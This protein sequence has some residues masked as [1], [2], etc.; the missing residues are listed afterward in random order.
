MGERLMAFDKLFS[1]ITIGS[2]Q[3]PNRVVMSPMTT[4]YGTPEQE[5]SERLM[6]YLEA[7]AQGGVGL[8][9]LEVCSVALDHRYQP[10]SLSLSE[11][12]FIP[13]HQN[14]VAMAHKHGARIQPQ[15]THPGPESL[16]PFY[17]GKPGIGPS[18]NV[19]PA[20]FQSCRPLDIEEIPAV[21]QQYAD[22][23]VRAQK[24]GY[25]GIELHAAHAYM[26]LGS[27]L[28]PLRN[29]RSDEYGG[30][31][32][33]GRARLL[34]ETL[35]AIRA[36][37][38]TEFPITVSLSGYERSPGGSEMNENQRLAQ[39]LV[40][41][42]ASAFRISGGSTDGLVSQM[43]M[44]SDYKDGINVTAAESIKRVV[45]V[46]VMVV[47]R[48]HTP[49]HAEQILE[50]GSADL[51]AM[52][53]PFLADPEWPR[54]ARSGKAAD[55]RR[56]I[57]CENCIDSMIDFQNLNCAVNARTGRE[58]ANV[59]VATEKAKYVLVVGGGPAGMEVARVANLRGH[60]VTL[61]ERQKRLGGAML[62][63]STVH[64]DN[65]PFYQ[66]LTRQVENSTID[67]R[68]GQEA[69]TETIASENPDVVIVATGATVETPVIPGAGQKHVYSGAQ[70][71]RMVEALADEADFT[72]LPTLLRGP[73]SWLMRYISPYLTPQLIRQLTRIW[74]PLGNRVVI[75]GAD[76]AA[77]ELA[78]FLVCR[79]RKVSMLES[80][81]RFAQ[82]IGPKRRAEHMDRLDRLGVTINTEADC[83]TILADAVRYKTAV[84]VR[85][86]IPADSV[87]LAG[88]PVASTQ[89]Y[90]ALQGAAFEVHA[91][92]DCTGLGLIRKAT[93]DAMRLACSI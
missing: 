24:A 37:V 74:L 2:M 28:S 9:T 51:I 87:I 23:A 56:C 71:R 50:D 81:K 6:A 90:E 25:D 22:G 78:E 4:G 70:F 54:K 69:S 40:E 60:K 68:L 19:N 3:L 55:I 65:Q 41:A 27:F 14:L 17:E 29:A 80:N 52:A 12:R 91:I 86:T 31:A 44:G 18:V 77:I 30:K 39:M 72:M 42:G 83:E 20:G 33:R 36:A 11:D 75:I 59:V 26:L 49:E 8:I 84:G 43:V 1:P 57:S 45:D 46:P 82:E 73:A 63:A 53:R 13:L 85:K 21:I 67:L 88:E 61:L 35:S 79:G 48:I 58:L 32:L 76:L 62:L 93:D 16:A 92:G 38:G 34:V 64:A 10:N 66:W 5:P 89:L 7:R 15:L 47:G